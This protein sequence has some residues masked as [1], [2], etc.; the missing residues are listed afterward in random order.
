MSIGALGSLARE[1]AFQLQTKIRVKQ[2]VGYKVLLST[3]V[4]ACTHTHTSGHPKILLTLTHACVSVF[5]K[6]GPACHLVIDLT[7]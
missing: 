7:M 5:Y 6:P 3:Q 4:L 2:H 1:L